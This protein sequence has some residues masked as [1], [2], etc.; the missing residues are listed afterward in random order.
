MYNSLQALNSN[1][2]DYSHYLIFNTVL[3]MSTAGEWSDYTQWSECSADCGGG[4]QSRTRVCITQGNNGT[5]TAPGL[6]MLSRSVDSIF[7]HL[8]LRDFL[9][10]FHNSF[11]DLSVLNL[12]NN[13]FHY[14]SKTLSYRK[15]NRS[16]KL[17]HKTLLC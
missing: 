12:L 11:L 6:W 14:L 9:V 8:F 15:W 3:I 4:F 16:E 10:S 7:R 13:P 17:Q 2:Q 1:F 5:C